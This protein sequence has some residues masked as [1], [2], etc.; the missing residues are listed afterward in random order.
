MQAFEKKKGVRTTGWTY[1]VVKLSSV[2]PNWKID[3][4]GTAN[5]TT[6][7]FL[8]KKVSGNWTVVD[9]GATLA[10]AQLK[11]DG[12]PSDSRY[13]YPRPRRRSSPRSRRYSTT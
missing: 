4:G 12:A 9:A 6:T 1:S 5:G 8:L 3:S 2:D 11:A 10:P 13:S 7:Y